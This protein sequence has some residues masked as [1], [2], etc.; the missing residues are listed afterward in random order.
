[1]N[2]KWTSIK[3]RAH[4]DMIFVHIFVLAAGGAINTVQTVCEAISNIFYILEVDPL[5][6]LL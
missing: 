2:K 3:Q 6:K 5:T 4:T 1:M